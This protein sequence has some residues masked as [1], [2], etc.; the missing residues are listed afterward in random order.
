[1]AIKMELGFDDELK[2]SIVKGISDGLINFLTKKKILAEELKVSSAFVWMKSNYVDSSVADNVPKNIS[3]NIEQ[4]GSWKYISFEINRGK[5]T[6]KFIIK[7]SMVLESLEDPNYYLTSY[8]EINKDLVE[9]D[10]FKKKFSISEQIP[11]SKQLVID[12]LI[13]PKSIVSDNNETRLYI[14]SYDFNYEKGIK[15][16]DIFIPY[17]G[18]A[19]L[20]DSLTD[21]VSELEVAIPE[22]LLKSAVEPEVPYEEKEKVDQ[23]MFGKL[24][25]VRSNDDKR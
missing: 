21:M 15:D 14:I 24:K 20:V 8:A 4:V 2:R 22:N 25:I 10:E 11:L 16:I 19:Y 6:Y 18:N 9:S 5:E 1:M 13:V 23:S 3:Y 17:D 7:P 12:N